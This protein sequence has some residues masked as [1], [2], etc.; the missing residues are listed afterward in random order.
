MFLLIFKVM[1]KV[2]KLYKNKD[3]AEFTE[4]Y[5]TQL[6]FKGKQEHISIVNIPNIAYPDQL[7][8]IEIPH[9]PRN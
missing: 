5:R 3:S 6:T 7:I 8:D 2:T 1:Y 4:N 9:G